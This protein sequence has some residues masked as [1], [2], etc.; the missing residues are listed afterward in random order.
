MLNFH[1]RHARK[2]KK[3]KKYLRENE[4]MSKENSSACVLPQF[5]RTQEMPLYQRGS[6]QAAL[7]ALPGFIERE[8]PKSS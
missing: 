5:R 3:R 1:I 6:H 4:N 2:V 8:T 7:T